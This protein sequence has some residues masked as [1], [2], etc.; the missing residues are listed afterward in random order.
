V[1]YRQHANRTFRSPTP[2]GKPRISEANWSARYAPQV[3]VC[4]DITYGMGLF[5]E[6]Q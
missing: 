6:K 4:E 5:V 3:M 2:E 1:P